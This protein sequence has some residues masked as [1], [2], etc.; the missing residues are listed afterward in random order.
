MDQLETNKQKTGLIFTVGR[1]PQPLIFSIKHFNPDFIVF[2]VTE[3]SKSTSLPTIINEIQLSVDQFDIVE[4]E[5]SPNAIGDLCTKLN[6]FYHRLLEKGITHVYLDASGGRKWMS[7]G[8]VMTASY[9]GIQMVYVDAQYKS[10]NPSEESMKLVDL[11]NAYE[12]TGFLGASKGRDAYNS[13]HYAE[14]AVLF[15]SLTPP[16][17]NKRALFKGLS[18][19]CSQLAKWDR[20]EHYDKSVSSGILEAVDYIQ[21]TH[22]SGL[23]NKE[24]GNF[25]NG[26]QSF[27][28][29]IKSFESKQELSIQFIADLFLNAERCISRKRYDDAVARH[30]R[31]LEAISQFLLK[32]RGIDTADVNFSLLTDE[33]KE[34]YES[35]YSIQDKKIDLY[36]GFWLLKSINHP[37]AAKVFP[38]QLH[39]NF[40]FRGI[41]ND[42]N[43]SILA[44]GLEPIDQERAEKFHTNLKT[45]LGTVFSDAF[46]Q[47]LSS[48]ELPEMPEVGF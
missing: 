20:F 21:S 27:V 48:L 11:G 44:H 18:E 3:N 42:R 36:K 35:H 14:A 16:D 8:A 13:Y 47:A 30:Y 45:L 40:K 6:R 12:Q 38:N 1:S 23:M 34:V 31:M 25:I 46:H 32:E 33:Q 9:L 4:I 17:A 39:K 28:N 22:N 2:F 43:S 26:I 15:G 5:D 19:L 24:V 29:Y 41:L 7:A 37:I 10:N